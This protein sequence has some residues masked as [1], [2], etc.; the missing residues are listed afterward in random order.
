MSDWARTTTTTAATATATTKH[1]SDEVLTSLTTSF[2]QNHISQEATDIDTLQAQLR[3]ALSHATAPARSNSQSQPP[4]TP[5]QTTA[6]SS[7]STPDGNGPR[8]RLG[9]RQ[10]GSRSNTRSGQAIPGEGEDLTMIEEERE[11]EHILEHTSPTFGF[12]YPPQQSHS[13]RPHIH[14]ASS[15]AATDP[16]SASHFQAHQ[17]HVPVAPQSAFF[18]YPPN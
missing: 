18:G 8:N 2:S 13:T 16:F 4:N 1:E 7:F 12:S 9:H 6:L 14:P 10:R 5:T 17:S 11:V 3:Q 15:F